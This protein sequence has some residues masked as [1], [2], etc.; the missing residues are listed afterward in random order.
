MLATYPAKTEEFYMLIT[1]HLYHCNLRLG[2]K[3]VRFLYKLETAP[4]PDVRVHDQLHPSAEAP[5]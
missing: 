2:L 4:V 1:Y 5:I 3:A